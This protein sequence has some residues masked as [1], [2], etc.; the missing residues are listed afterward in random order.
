MRQPI[1]FIGQN[2]HPTTDYVKGWPVVNIQID[3]GFIAPTDGSLVRP[4]FKQ[5]QAL[6]DTGSDHTV[7]SPAEVDGIAPLRTINATNQGVV[8]RAGVYNALMLVGNFEKPHHLQIAAS[9]LNGSYTKILIGR[10]TL[11]RYRMVY[12]A[13][14]EEFYLDDMKGP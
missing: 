8:Y 9:S 10:D 13:P 14:K 4:H 11:E 6:I 7:I 12:N 5:Y 1:Y 3:I 2:G